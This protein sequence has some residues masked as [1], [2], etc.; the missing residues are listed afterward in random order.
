[1]ENP[2]ILQRKKNIY[3]LIKLI[4]GMKD[5]YSIKQ[6]LAVFSY[7]TGLSVYTVRYDYFKILVDSGI[8]TIDKDNNKVIKVTE[9]KFKESLTEVVF[10]KQP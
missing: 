8:I 7:L 2:N 10:I 9:L 1:M 5:T 3:K 6:T 4:K